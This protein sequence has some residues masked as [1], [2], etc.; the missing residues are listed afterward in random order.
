MSNET[1]FH[2]VI[3]TDSNDGTTRLS[4]GGMA[5]LGSRAD[6]ERIAAWHRDGLA[7]GYARENTADKAYRSRVGILE[8]PKADPRLGHPLPYTSA[9]V[10]AWIAAGHPRAQG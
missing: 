3:W 6:A 2:V 4:I 7:L 8:M 9:E 1:V 10:D 5:T